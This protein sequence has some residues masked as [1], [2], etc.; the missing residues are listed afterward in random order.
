VILAFTFVGV[1][2][3]TTPGAVGTIQLSFTLALAPYG[4]SAGGAVA[5]SVFWH[6]F[7]YCFVVS[8]GFFYFL[9]MGYSFGEIRRQAREGDLVK[10]D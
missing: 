7:A 6:V 2:L 4:V 8:T 1:T 3:P 10:V 9:R 5:A